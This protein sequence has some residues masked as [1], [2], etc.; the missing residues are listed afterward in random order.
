MSHI[1]GVKVER[2][3]IV[4]DIAAF[5]RGINPSIPAICVA[6]ATRGP[7]AASASGPTSRIECTRHYASAGRPCRSQLSALLGT[8][9]FRRS[10]RKSLGAIREPD[11]VRR[12]NRSRG[13]R[14]CVPWR[15]HWPGRLLGERDRPELGRSPPAPDLSQ[16]NYRRVVADN[17][18]TI[19]PD[20]AL[21]GELEISGVRQVD[22]LKGPAWLTCLKLDAQGRPPALRH[23][24][25]GQQ[26]HRLR[27]PAS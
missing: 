27:A 18:K 26:D 1:R 5:R 16:P 8:T 20:Q 4:P 17:I 7:A 11:A 23:L 15:Q 22:H 3:I 2:R 10:G 13:C 19:F 9:R 6:G 25:P 14:E 12:D 21:L 24:H